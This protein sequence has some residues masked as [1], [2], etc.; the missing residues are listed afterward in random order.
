[1][2]LVMR[3]SNDKKV[4]PF[5]KFDSNEVKFYNQ[6]KNDP[7]YDSDL[8][9]IDYDDTIFYDCFVHNNKSL[10]CDN[11]IELQEI[12]D[13]IVSQKYDDEEQRIY[14]L[15]EYLLE[16]P[17]SEINFTYRFMLKNLENSMKN[18][19]EMLKSRIDTDIPDFFQFIYVLSLVLAKDYDKIMQ[20]YLN[21]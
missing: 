14:S 6:I 3:L 5:V 16:K 15:M 8:S 4:I 1:M 21:Q 2:K 13:C 19:N 20:D 17:K 12:I 7:D 9:A 18:K 10:K 11:T